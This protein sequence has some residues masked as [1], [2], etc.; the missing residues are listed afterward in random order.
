LLLCFSAPSYASNLPHIINYTDSIVVE[1]VNRNH[2]GYQLTLRN[3]SNVAVYGVAVA[4]FGKHGN[5]DLHM[6]KSNWG[7][8]MDPLG[9]R[10]L[11]LLPL[12]QSKNRLGSCSDTGGHGLK[13]DGFARV[14]IGAVDFENGNY[15]GDNADAALLEANRFGRESQYAKISNLVESELKLEHSAG[16]DW[17]GPLLTKVSALSDTPDPDAVHSIENR[18]GSA[19]ALK[20]VPEEMRSG[21]GW[22]KVVF[23]NNLRIYALVTSKKG[24]PLVSLRTWW[25][26]TKGACDYYVPWCR[27]G[28]WQKTCTASQ[29]RT[30]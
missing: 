14:V 20:C 11:D 4:V 23:T 12:H 28:A 17:T 25:D 3:K 26:S 10:E 29:V 27:D 2:S 19:V 1:S 8:L 24:L 7:S 9:T 21:S 22:A 5:C 6:S 13:S 30:D 15:E 18:F 16:V